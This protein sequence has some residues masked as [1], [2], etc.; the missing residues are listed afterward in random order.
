MAGMFLGSSGPLALAAL[1]QQSMS[2]LPP[3]VMEARTS[4]VTGWERP[5]K[6]G[7]QRAGSSILM[8]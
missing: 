6:V 5:T 2:T 3:V 7:E 8:F 4:K 1:F